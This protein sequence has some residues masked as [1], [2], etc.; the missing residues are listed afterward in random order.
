MFREPGSVQ[1]L[2]CGYQPRSHH[3]CTTTIPRRRRQGYKLQIYSGVLE[4][5]YHDGKPTNSLFHGVRSGSGAD[6]GRTFSAVSRLTTGRIAVGGAS[7]MQS[8]M[9]EDVEI[10]DPLSFLREDART[11]RI[12]TSM[13]SQR[14]N[15]FYATAVAAMKLNRT[16]ENHL[17]CVKCR[18]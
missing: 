7:V 13:I 6:A 16:G 14:S 3:I 15:T 5:E 10:A 1:L 17:D 9:R 2:E 4:I 12:L 11:L 8:L 18:Q